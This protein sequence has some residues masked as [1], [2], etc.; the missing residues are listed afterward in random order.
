MASIQ[1]HL[2]KYIDVHLSVR[3]IDHTIELTNTLLKRPKQ[4][5][6][7]LD[8][9]PIHIVDRV[10][11]EESANLAIMLKNSFLRYVPDHD[12]ITTGK[13]DKEGTLNFRIIHNAVYY[14]KI[15]QKDEHLPSTNNI[16]RQHLTIESTGAVS[17]AITKT[18]IKELLIKRDIA[19]R[20]LTLFDWGKLNAQKTWTFAACDD[21]AEQFIFMDIKPDGCFEFRELDGTSLFGYQEYQHYIELISQ[22]KQEEWKTGL[23]IEGLVVSEE[24]DINLIF[25]T[26]EISLPDLSKIEAIIKEVEAELPEN[27]LSGHALADTVEEFFQIQSGMDIEKLKLFSVELRKTGN[28]TISKREF[29]S[30]IAQYLGAKKKDDNYVSSTTEATRFR[31]YLLDKYQ[32][33]LKF[34]QDNQSKDDLFDASLNIK[35]FG[36]TEKEAYYFVGERKE[37]VQFSFK[38]ACHLRKIIG[39]N[40]SKLIFRQ[41]LPTMDVDFVRTGQSTVVPF[42]F[43]YIREYKNFSDEI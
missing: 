21:K 11:D 6:A 32:I 13:R 3:E 7:K 16:Q 10:N 25:R 18:I 5:H 29:K 4:L 31:D 20:T 37:N 34:P 40:G 1:E 28:Q 17:E 30:L 43:K 19:F 2:S 36:E 27:T 23:Y 26:N 41:L 15:G 8:R 24:G 33:R 22:A 39:V 35:Y 12:L 42:P 14:E 38:D 9:Q